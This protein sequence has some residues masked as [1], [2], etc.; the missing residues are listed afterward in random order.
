[1]IHIFSRRPSNSARALTT[2]L[3][4]MGLPARRL[5][6]DPSSRPKEG[7]LIVCWGETYWSAVHGGRFL[8]QHYHMSKHAQLR[9]FQEHGVPTVEFCTHNP[10]NAEWFA[11]IN[12][13]QKGLD[14]LHGVEY[15]DY[16]VRREPIQREFRVHIFK[17]KSIRT[18]IKR[19][20]PIAHEWVRTL[21]GGWHLDY[22]SECQRYIRNVHRDAA[23]NACAALGLDFGAVDIGSTVDGRVLVFEVNT[24]PG[25]EGNTL[26]AYAR[27]ISGVFHGEDLQGSEEDE[28]REGEDIAE[29]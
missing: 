13:H 19:P 20:G 21:P 3:R 8:N 11:R 23:R 28:A 4:E 24:A 10:Q 15:P 1:M 22:G 5:R 25:L 12:G 9:K 2:V 26:T 17:G 7:D 27:K 14:L 18:G 16:Y 29:I 6:R